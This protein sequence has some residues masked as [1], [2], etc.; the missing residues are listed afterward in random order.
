MKHPLWLINSVLLL[1]CIAII[2]F[3]CIDTRK[4]PKRTSLAV[5]ALSQSKQS[6]MPSFDLK[7]IYTDD[8]FE[9]YQ[10]IP[11]KTVEHQDFAPKL[12]EI[13]QQPDQ[14]AIVIPEE[15][16][17]SFLPPL[18]IK[19]KGVMCVDNES[20][21]KAIIA[22]NKTGTQTMFKV[23]DIVQDARLVKILSNRI[24]IIRS[25]GQQET[26]YLN[27]KDLNTSPFIKEQNERWLHVVKNINPE[28]YLLDH[29][30]FTHI[31]KNVAQCI[32]IFDIT[33]S[34]KN[35]KSI[36]CK[37]GFLDSGSL[38]SAMGLESYDTIMTIDSLSLATTEDRII[39]FNYLATL[40]FT[41]T[42]TVNGIRQGEPFTL[43][44]LLRDL[45]DPFDELR[46]EKQQ[47]PGIITGQSEDELEEEKMNI[48]RQRY[49]FAPTVEDIKI[50]QKK[51]MLEKHKNE[52][53]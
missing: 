52:R 46:S 49:I 10:E 38:G 48:L 31:I 50:E 22:D 42:I 20:L 51:A 36:G 4:L 53:E 32:D 33:T 23:G 43:H 37:I 21:N 45:K 27:E 30:S 6:A 16:Q 39:L 17:P 2:G 13:P 28:H 18:D 26:L 8:L 47:L 25:N 7:K 40:T 19:L 14:K 35:G 1:S 44:Y 29:E 9:T 11:Q 41:Q 15:P 5:S 3:V 12:P 34:Y 24:I